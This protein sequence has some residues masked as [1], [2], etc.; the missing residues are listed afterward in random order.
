MKVRGRWNWF[1]ICVQ[2]HTS[3]L[4]V[5]NLQ[6]LLMENWL[7]LN[8]LHGSVLQVAY[9]MKSNCNSYGYILSMNCSLLVS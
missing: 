7:I 8:H 9:S 3:V 2:V 5:L 4:G 6:I 1:S